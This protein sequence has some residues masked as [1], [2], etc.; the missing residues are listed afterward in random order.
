MTIETGDPSHRELPTSSKAHTEGTELQNAYAH[1][2][3]EQEL[4]RRQVWDTLNRH[5]FRR[6]VD[7]QDAVLDVG[8]GYCEFI[9]S[10][11]AR[12]KFALDLNPATASH[13]EPGVEVLTQDI[14]KTWSL[15]SQ[16]I[17]V[18]FTSNFLEHL[19]S[20]QALVHCLQEACR[21]LRPHGRLIALGPNIRY[22]Y[23]VYWDYFDHT[24]ALSDKSLAEALELNG[25]QLEKVIPR[26]LP[27][28]M[29]SNA[30][31]HAAFVRLY[32]MLPLAWRIFCKQF[33]ITAR[34]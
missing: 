21:V 26:F 19:P 25:F 17:D 16:S 4:R 1:R 27:F 9:N 34:T 29:K 12:Q 6:W 2:F 13:A 23:K 14:C 32:L 28:T 10:I 11:H 5:F 18:V 33:L 22:A 7:P 3:R 20:K 31:S 24:L 8:A 15:P 30:P